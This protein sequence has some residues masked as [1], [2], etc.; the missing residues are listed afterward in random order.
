M[1]GSGVT[2]MQGIEPWMTEAF[3]ALSHGNDQDLAPFL[4]CVS[5]DVG[6]ANTETVCRCHFL[7]RD[8]N[9]RPVVDRL[10]AKVAAQAIQYCIPRTRLKEAR[11]ELEKTERFEKVA[12]LQEEA[13]SLF[14][15]IDKS[16]EGGEMLLYLL[17]EAE[18]GLPQLLCKMPLKT[19]SRVHFHG[20]DGIHGSLEE[21]GRLGLYWCESKLHKE[22]GAATRDCFESL[23][24]FLLDEGTKASKRDLLL[25]R[26]H[27][28][29]ADSKLSDALKLYLDDDAIQSTLRVVKGASLIGFSLEEYPNPFEADGRSVAQ[30]VSEQVQ[31]WFDAIGKHVNRHK[32][33]SFEIEVFCLPMPDVEAFRKAIKTHLH[34]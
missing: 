8:G 2:Q 29:L 5:R 28:D 15:D 32:L 21:D 17:L 25:V 27:L 33:D 31:G 3:N 22:V 23:A 20:V 10:A 16:G 18:L 14:T 12:R 34:L 7:K 1:A 19:S 11:E 6:L 13:R 4:S 26:D 30:E 24:P 9:D